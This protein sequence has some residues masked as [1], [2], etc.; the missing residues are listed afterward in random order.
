MTK[1]HLS[2]RMKRSDFVYVDLSDDIAIVIRYNN[3]DVQY[4]LCEKFYNKI[5][6]L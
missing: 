4:R 3:V 1:T 2:L 6:N 5:C